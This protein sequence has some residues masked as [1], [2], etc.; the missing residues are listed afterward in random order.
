[1]TDKQLID[2]LEKWRAQYDFNFQVWSEDRVNCSI[3]KGDI[4]LVGFNQC[5]T[6][7]EGFEKC[8]EWINKQN[9]SGK[10]S[11]EPIGGRCVQ[12]GCRIA[13][14]NDICGECACEDDCD[15]L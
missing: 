15:Y 3:Q 13:V 5:E 11:P 8:I 9:P 4:S 12:C 14:G 10:V 1:M 7:R 2:A 6:V